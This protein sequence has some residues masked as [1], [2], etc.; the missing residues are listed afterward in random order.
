MVGIFPQEADVYID[1]LG[2]HKT[3]RG[4]VTELSTLKEE[5]FGKA[6]EEELTSSQ[7][8]KREG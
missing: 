4:T 2:S 3:T 1:G 5:I 8:F 7:V 6:F